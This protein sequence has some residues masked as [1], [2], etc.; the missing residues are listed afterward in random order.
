MVRYQKGSNQYQK[1]R[2]SREVIPT[3][4]GEPPVTAPRYRCGGIWGST[5]PTLVS[6]PNYSHGMH[7]GFERQLAAAKTVHTIP[8]VLLSLGQCSGLSISLAQNPNTPMALLSKLSKDVNPDVRW[9]VASQ[10]NLSADIITTLSKDPD[11]TVRERI[12]QH[13]TVMDG[14]LT[15]LS[16]DDDWTI[17]LRVAEH[18]NTSIKVLNQASRDQSIA[19]REGVAQNPHTAIGTLHRLARDADQYVRRGVVK[20]PNVSAYLVNMLANDTAWLV[21]HSVAAHPLA[22]EQTVTRLALHDPIEEIRS[23]AVQ[24]PNTPKHIKAMHALSE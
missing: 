18:A 22:T 20:N 6:P 3:I 10:E 21:R 12:A 9:M 14:V 15:L 5:C 23:T 1:S 24:H 19:V 2:Q 11:T 16:Q 17:R 13:P 7:P 4:G 8:D